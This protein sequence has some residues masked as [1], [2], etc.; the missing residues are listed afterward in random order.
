ME[1][2]TPTGNNS[3]AIDVQVGLRGAYPDFNNRNLTNNNT[4]WNIKYKCWY[5]KYGRHV[6]Q[7]NNEIT[8]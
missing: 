7:N 8:D 1:S 5:I 3:T 2:S 6:E 4:N